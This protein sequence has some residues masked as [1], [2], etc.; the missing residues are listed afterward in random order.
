[1]ERKISIKE[2]VK[3]DKTY[4][5]IQPKK[6]LEAGDHF[7]VEKLFDVGRELETEYG[8][9]WS[10]TLGYDGKDVGMFMSVKEY[11]EFNNVASIGDK[12]KITYTSKVVTFRKDGKPQERKYLGLKFE[13]V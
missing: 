13:K 11:E 2:T 1:M 4:Y 8:K 10:V 6:E 12:V 7:I 3:G 9:A 5:N